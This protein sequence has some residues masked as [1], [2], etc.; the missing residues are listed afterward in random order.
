M[1]E[2]VRRIRVLAL[3]AIV[4]ALIVFFAAPYVRAT[5]FVLDVSGAAPG[6]RRWLP[7]RAAAVRERDVTV[8]TRYGPMPARVYEPAGRASRSIV[9][10]PGVHAGGTD[11]PR[12][13]A[14]SR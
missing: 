7:V 3:A 8:P 2:S 14:F 9:V 5:A 6:V 10:F 1:I 12:L 11:E 13:V 4:V